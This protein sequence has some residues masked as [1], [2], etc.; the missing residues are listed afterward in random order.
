MFV[1]EEKESSRATEIVGK[2]TWIIRQHIEVYCNHYNV[3]PSFRGKLFLLFLHLFMRGGAV[4]AQAEILYQVMRGIGRTA[5][6]IFCF[7]LVEGLC[8]THDVKRYLLRL[9]AFALV[10]AYS[11]LIWHCLTEFSEFGVTECFFYIVYWDSSGVYSTHQMCYG[12]AE[13]GYATEAVTFRSDR[14]C[15]NVGGLFPEN[16]LQ[17]NGDLADTDLLC[18]QI[19]QSQGMRSWLYQYD[20]G[21][22]CASRHLSVSIFIMAKRE[23]EINGSFICFIRCICCFCMPC[24]S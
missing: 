24:G 7:V 19:R 15:G 8:H 14:D 6:P 23:M 2:R 16:R 9:F 1:K 12:E 5:F 11:H 13:L 20:V 21:S 10:S 17:W 3:D 4:F 22:A 18:V